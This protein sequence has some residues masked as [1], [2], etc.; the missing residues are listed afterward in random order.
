MLLPYNTNPSLASSHAGEE[1]KK[2]NADV[3][4]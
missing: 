3:N 4:V 2:E 1:K